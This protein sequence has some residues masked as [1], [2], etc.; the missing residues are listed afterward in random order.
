MARFLTRLRSRARPS[1]GIGL[2]GLGVLLAILIATGGEDG[3]GRPPPADTE[4][5]LVRACERVRE[6]VTAQR[7]ARAAAEVTAEEPL[8]ATETASATVDGPEGSATATATVTVRGT[9]RA[10]ARAELSALGRA[11]GS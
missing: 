2:A 5:E 1:L 9:S 7:T 11:R 6:R 8:S 3:T 4:P 10:T